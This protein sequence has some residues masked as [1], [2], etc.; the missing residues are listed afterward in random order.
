[1]KAAVS[2]DRTT[3]LQL[4]QHSETPSQK[5]KF[6]YFLDMSFLVRY[7]YC[8]YFLNVF[9]L[10]FHFLDVVFKREEVL[11]SE[12]QLIIIFSYGSCF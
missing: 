2:S 9:G 7:W 10:P 12:V 6:L 5:E 11:N 4:W 1:M 3:V 8:I